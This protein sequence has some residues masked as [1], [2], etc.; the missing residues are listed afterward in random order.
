MAAR[1]RIESTRRFQPHRC[2]F[3]RRTR[4][5]NRICKQQPAAKPR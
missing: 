5:V 1:R 4:I 2:D 3:Y